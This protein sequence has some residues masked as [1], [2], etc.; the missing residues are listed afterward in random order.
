MHSIFS[1]FQPKELDA[2]LH[3]SRCSLCLLRACLERQPSRL[4]VKG[5]TATCGMKDIKYC[6]G[7]KK[8]IM[9]Q[10]FLVF[11]HKLNFIMICSL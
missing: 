3:H 7:I 6:G 10:S 8:K 9:R 11:L 1:Y 2:A 5:L 4:R